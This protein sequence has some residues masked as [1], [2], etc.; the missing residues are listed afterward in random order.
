MAEHFN[1]L[2]PQQTEL[3][4]VIAEEAAEVIQII[5]K[6]K[7][8]G[9]DSHDPVT[10]KGNREW[11]EDELMDFLATSMQLSIQGEIDNIYQTSVLDQV[12]AKKLKWMHHQ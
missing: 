10:G 8:H 6:I 3:L 1:G 12:W 7:R 5:S 4:D 11:L 2:T 9:Y